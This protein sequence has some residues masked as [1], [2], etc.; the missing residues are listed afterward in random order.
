MTRKAG[1]LR[2]ADRLLGQTATAVAAA[3]GVGLVGQAQ[4]AHAQIVYS[5]PVNITIP[6]TTAGV[7]LNVVTGVNNPSPSGAP[8]WDVNPWGSGSFFLYGTGTGNGFASNFAGGTSATLADNL[9][10]GTL[11]DGSFTYGNNG[12]E[13]TAQQPLT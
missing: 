11:V 1:F 4:E 7:Y 8:G 6:T 13:T 10:L 12:V 5:G 2:N 9:P 3:T